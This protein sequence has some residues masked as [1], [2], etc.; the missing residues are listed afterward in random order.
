VTEVRFTVV[1]EPISQGSK[2][3]FIPTYRNGF[4]VR[5]HKPDCMFFGKKGPP[6]FICRCPL[7]VNMVEDNDKELK[8]WREAVAWTARA[9]MR[10]RE[11][12]EGLVATF[13]TFH[14]HRPKGHYGTGR[15]A[16][17]VK[18]GAPAAPGV[19]PDVKKLA[20]AV[21]D[22]LSGIVYA[23]DAQVVDSYEGKRYV[24]PWEDERVDVVVRP[25]A[26]QTAGE[27]MAIGGMLHPEEEFG[28]LD[29]LDAVGA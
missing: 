21:E 22:A 28:Q 14:L 4:P 23:D 5:R 18:P 13:H 7:M 20:R 29:L 8:A 2:T 25:L 24:H 26:V 6:E 16:R 11:P 1:G 17:I 19:I 27:L 12:I 10:S 9:A 15:N 3:P